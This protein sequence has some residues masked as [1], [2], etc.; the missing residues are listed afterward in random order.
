M[1]G[2][3]RPEPGRAVFRGGLSPRVRGNPRPGI[4]GRRRCGSIPACAGEPPPNT[5]A[6][7]P[8][9]VYPRVCGGTVNERHGLNASYGLSPRVRGNHHHPQC[10]NIFEGSIPA[11]AGE[12]QPGRPLL[13]RAEVYPRVCGGTDMSVRYLPRRPGLSPRVRGNH[14]ESP[15]GKPAQRS[16]PACAGEP[17][18]FQHHRCNL[19]VYPRVC[20]GTIGQRGPL[21]RRRAP[22][23]SIPACA[24]EP[25]ECPIRW[26]ATEVYPRVCGGT[27]YYP[28][29][30]HWQ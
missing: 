16:I 11:C 13:R 29:Y 24:G 1:C 21:R 5:T 27:L 17:G 15:A 26:D 30:R 9:G 12:P 28:E 14:R 10:Q 2:G 18:L 23:G 22:P 25:R 4:A 3:T 6:L 7:A 20:G 8:S 19:G